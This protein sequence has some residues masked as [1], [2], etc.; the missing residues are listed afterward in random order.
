LFRNRRYPE[1]QALCLELLKRQPEQA[2]VLHL[3]SL[4]LADCGD[5]AGALGCIEQALTL[6]AQ[7]PRLLGSYA[8]MLFRAWRL[9]EAER[10]ARAALDLQPQLADVVDILGSILWRRGNVDAA[11]ECFERALQQAPGH[12]GAWGNLTLLNE[13]SNRVA[14]AERMAEEGLKRR[15]QD[16]MLRLV[17]GRCLRRRGEFARARAQLEPLAQG[18]TPALRRE[19]GL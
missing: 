9:E 17:R 6:D 13:Q 10:A 7:N 15:P 3:L 11:R 19:C 5:M 8:L 4:I 1:A 2:P 16:V 12:A 18:G 14:E